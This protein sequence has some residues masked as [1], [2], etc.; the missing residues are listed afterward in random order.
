MRVSG[1]GASLFLCSVP[2][3]SVG[4]VFCRS[5]IRRLLRSARFSSCW[6]MLG[7]FVFVS[8]LLTVWVGIL[9]V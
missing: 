1:G 4:F 9:V 6:L 5:F 2:S 3:F 8:L 7:F